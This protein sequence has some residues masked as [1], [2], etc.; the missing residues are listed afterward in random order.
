MKK[1]GIIT[2]NDYKNYGNRL[3]NYATQEVLK[4]LG[5]EAE[6]IVN[7]INKI[8]HATKLIPSVRMN[9]LEERTRIIFQNIRRKLYKTTEERKIKI[10]NAAKKAAF[11][12]FTFE[13][14]TETPFVI[15][16]NNIPTDL[17]ERYDAF[18]VGS[19]QVWNPCLRGVASFD[20]LMFAQKD[21]RISYAASFGI[22]KIP[23][24]FFEDY[25]CWLSE[26]AHV[27]VRE[28]AGAK[29]VKELT[30]RDALV[31]VDPTL[32]LT[33]E[34]WLSLAEKATHQPKTPYLLTYFL[35][36]LSLENRERINAIAKE[37]CL[38]IVSL[39]NIDDEIRYATGPREFLDYI[40][41]SEVFL[42][43][44]FHG[45]VFSILFEKAFILF[46]RTSKS[47]SMNSRINTLLSKFEL[48]NRKADNIKVGKNIFNVDF[49]HVP[50]I[51]EAERKKAIDYLK[52]ALE[53]TDDDSSSMHFSADVKHNL[54]L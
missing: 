37:T 49:S 12:K 44:S 26:M 16:S 3:Q 6:T 51:L 47:P 43:D 21:K 18:I 1:I 25:R 32:M 29:I 45:A 23:E 31:L 20:F 34:K 24:E 28:D 22:S 15:N 27:S 11:K 5:C 36:D 42:T 53:I 19:D 33:K 46:D 52:N 2:I 39:A 54:S 10:M 13:V 17:D 48:L 38:E 50:L 4:S 41:S 7:T 40:N 9:S 30:G 14:I 8:Q 35:G